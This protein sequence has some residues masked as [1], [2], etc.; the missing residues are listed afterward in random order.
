MVG[1]I[2]IYHVALNLFEM[3]FHCHTKKHHIVA[4]KQMFFW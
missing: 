1:H 4:N 2:C 3:Y